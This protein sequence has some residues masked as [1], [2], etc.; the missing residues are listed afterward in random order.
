M[1]EARRVIARLD[2]IEELRGEGAP[3]TVLLDEVRRLLRDGEDWLAAER[4]GNEPGTGGSSLDRA[5]GALARGREAVERCDL[6]R[7]W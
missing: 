1:E 3:A 5:A 7:G 6:R 4:A 2:R